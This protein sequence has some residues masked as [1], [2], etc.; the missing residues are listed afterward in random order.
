MSADGLAAISAGEK[1]VGTG[2]GLDLVG[3]E[4]SSPINFV[5]CPNLSLT[6]CYSGSKREGKGHTIKTQTLNSSAI[7]VSLLKN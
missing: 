2:V 6:Y 3:L 5:F 7:C 4:S 1:G